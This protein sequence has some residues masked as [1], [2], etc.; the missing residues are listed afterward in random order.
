VVTEPTIALSVA[1]TILKDQLREA[2]AI[3]TAS[4]GRAYEAGWN[5]CL[6]HLAAMTPE[7]RDRALAGP[8]RR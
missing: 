5:A 3:A 7:E 2:R 8:V 1:E 4:V 6:R